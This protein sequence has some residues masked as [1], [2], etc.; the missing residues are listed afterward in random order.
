MVALPIGE[1]RGAVGSS[2]AQAR[3]SLLVGPSRDDR[4]RTPRHGPRYRRASTRTRGSRGRGRRPRDPCRRVRDRRRLPQRA[5]ADAATPAG[6]VR[7]DSAIVRQLRGRIATAT[8]ESGEPIIRRELRT[9]AAKAGLRAMSI[10]IDPSRAVGGRLATGDRIDV[11]FAGDREVSIIVRDAEVIAIDAKGRGG[12]GETSSPFTVTIAVDAR[13]S[14]LLAAA[15]ADGDISLART[16]GARSSQGTA[17]QALDRGRRAVPAPGRRRARGTH[18]RAGLLARSSG[19][20]DSIGTSPTTAARVSAR[21]CSS[22][23]SR[24]KTSTTRSS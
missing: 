10:P 11:L 23:R 2:P 16:T 6:H 22:R 9:R 24:W 1:A 17:P 12:I 13:Q 18:D 3:R 7:A 15:I 4:R 8:I 21:S 20:N 5:R 14:Q 19:S